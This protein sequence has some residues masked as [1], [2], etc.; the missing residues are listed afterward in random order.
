MISGKSILARMVGSLLKLGGFFL[1]LEPIWMLLPFAGFLYGSVLHIED[2]GRNPYTSWLV[3]F[4]F[5]VHTL[6]PVGLI[7]TA[8]GFLLFLVGAFQIYSAKLLKKGL[9]DWGIYKKFRHPQYLALSLFGVGIILTWGRFITFIAFFIML[10]LYHLLAKSEERKCE[11]AFGERYK[12]YRQRTY[13]L[14][15]GEAMLAALGRRFPWASLPRWIVLPGS[16]LLVLGAAIGGGLVI[17]E[18]KSSLRKTIPVIEG[19][20]T[21]SSEMR[22]AIRLLMVKG[23]VL[24][25]SPFAG[26]REEIMKRL[27]EAFRSSEKIRTSVEQLDVSKEFTVLAF[28]TPGS[29]WHEQHHRLYRTTRVNVFLL[30][31]RTPVPYKGDNFGEFRK[32]W[33]PFK[34]IHAYD[35]CYGRIEVGQDPVAGEVITIG[36][37]WGMAIEP[38]RREM[39]ERVDFFLSGL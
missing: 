26:E 39:E 33:Q 35:M 14:F 24:Q 10:R 19:T 6:F 4:V 36:P 8:G 3:H 31:V 12:R 28:L 16:F 5:P 34:V 30:V 27:F 15:P 1:I 22:P 20:L 23:P 18:I 32:N 38:F 37:P 11:A 13:F 17:Q 2:L 25:A 9:V 7:L 21:L 29:D